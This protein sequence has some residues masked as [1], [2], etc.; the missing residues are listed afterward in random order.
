MASCRVCRRT[1]ST[2]LIATACALLAACGSASVHS[3][4]PAGGAVAAA[5][6]GSPPVLAAL[7]AQA[8]RL[9]SGGVAAFGARLRAL[10]G[11][12]IVVNKWASWCGPCQSEFPV[13]QRVSVTDGRTVAFIGIDGKDA[14]ASGGGFPATLPG[15]LSELRRPRRE[16]RPHDRSRDHYPQTVYIDRQGTVVFDHVGPM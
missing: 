2:A 14:D 11:H 4:E 16:H 5:F 7:H 15:Q 9:L 1:P 13:Y 6:R 12:P 3:A 8:G 10:R